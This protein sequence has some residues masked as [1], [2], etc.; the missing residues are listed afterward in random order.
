MGSTFKKVVY[1]IHLFI[2]GRACI[3]IRHQ[4]DK[5]MEE[6]CRNIPF[7]KWSEEFG[8]GYVVNSKEHLKLIFKVFKGEAWVDTS[9]FFKSSP[10][11]LS[12]K[13]FSYQAYLAPDSN[14]ENR[15][16]PSFLHK[17]EL[18]GYSLNTAKVYIS[19]F[20]R[21]MAYYS[22]RNVNHLDEQ[23]I[24]RYLQH[25][26]RKGMSPSYLNQHINAI[27]FYYEIVRGMPHRFY[28]LERP[29]KQKKL[30]KVLSKQE[31][32][33]MLEK[34]NNLKHRC[35]IELLYGAGL[36]R[37]EL[38]NLELNDIQ[39][40]R[41]LINIRDTKGNTE[42]FTL[43]SQQSLFNLRVYYREWKPK[44]YLFEGKRGTQYSAT[45]V[46]NIVKRSASRAGI[47]Q[48]VSPH[49]LRHSFATHLLEDGVDLRYIQQLLGHK[50]TKTTEIYTHVASHQLKKIKNPLDSLYLDKR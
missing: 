50:T 23:D 22:E 12:S 4:H 2:G 6:L 25:L 37:S 33:M 46:A 19:C 5:K 39:S 42:R 18:K 29:R 21:F 28:E 16:P 30:P 13:K 20:E 47:L 49:M 38:L 9:R 32:K 26:I 3:G 27:K 31:I 36:R 48:K 44:K 45:S 43:L 41:F 11:S 8:V 40:K 1:I 15:C 17:L 34:T 35:I 7:Y 10:V 14:S 24:R